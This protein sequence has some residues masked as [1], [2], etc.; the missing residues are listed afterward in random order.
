MGVRGLMSYIKE[1]H[2]FLKDCH[3]KDSK[4]IID[5][6]NLCFSLYRGQDFDIMHGG[7]YYAF[8]IVIKE[9]FQALKNCNIEPYVVLDGGSDHT[10]K[11]LE[12]LKQRAQERIKYG[13]D[14]ALGLKHYGG[15]KPVLLKSVFKE[16]LTRLKVPFVQCMEEADWETAALAHQWNCP[17][18]SDDSDFFIF[19]Q[20]AGFLPY[21]H[22][23]W[24]KGSTQKFIPA[25][26]FL[27]SNFCKC[28]NNMKTELVS[29]FAALAGNDYIK[30]QRMNVSFKWEQFSSLSGSHAR[31]DGILWWLSGF[32]S[33]EKAIG[34]LP[35]LLQDQDDRSAVS[36][37]LAPC[38][39]EYQLTQSNLA[40]FFLNG[41]APSRLPREL[42]IIP[43]WMRTPLCDGSMS[44]TFTDTLVL[45]RVR[46]SPQIENFDLPSS[47]EISRPIRQVMYGL[48]LAGQRQRD[49]R[50][51]TGVHVKPGECYV[52]EY[53]REGLSLTSVWVKAACPFSG[54]NLHLETLNQAPHETRLQVLCDTLRM[55]KPIPTS[56]AP[57]FQL[58]V[59]VTCYW[60][61]KADPHPRMEDLW[62]L[63]LGFVFGELSGRHKGKQ[64]IPL[65][66]NRLNNLR[67]FCMVGPPDLDLAHTYSQW[68]ACLY[69][70][71]KLNRLL[72]RALPEPE[73]ARLYCGPLVHQA[74]LRL[75]SGMST[76]SFLS[77]GPFPMQLFVDLQNAVLDSLDANVRDRLQKASRPNS[78]R[79]RRTKSVGSMDELVAQFQHFEVEDDEDEDY[80]RRGGRSKS[81]DDEDGKLRRAACHIRTR[82]KKKS[83]NLHPLNKRDRVNWA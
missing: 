11:K 21:S 61:S 12:T 20:K 72:C 18:L 63:L 57:K 42:E 77:A 14:V 6:S 49:H 2:Q 44:S 43:A 16:I 69:A 78:P 53:D 79:Q 33:S 22:F 65:V 45:Q 54:N 59:C 75:R 71:Y 68:Q 51:P 47:N 23:Q 60:L 66:W 31:I 67:R 39:R 7:D 64:G 41:L 82:H 10:D 50:R 1:N 3:F 26:K 62:A 76:E 13:R 52:E 29:L 5:G 27:I 74:A 58:A 34:A 17:V 55:T 83:R 8:E 73:L 40:Q 15:I 9:F 37:A 24:Q 36:K 19:G 4:L 46:L 80:G 32:Q 81:D 30:L 25:K 35:D 28:F 48:L 70:S 56:I 38:L